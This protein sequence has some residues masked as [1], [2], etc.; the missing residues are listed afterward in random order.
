M[1]MDL[2]VAYKILNCL[3]NMG[4]SANLTQLIRC[5]KSSATTVTRYVE[6]LKQTKLIVENNGGRERV[7]KL[8][9]RGEDFVLTFTK[10][11]SIIKEK[12]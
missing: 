3:R 8:T 9:S 5:S 12:A 10:L 11:L 6:I 1:R 7:F 4:G 2:C